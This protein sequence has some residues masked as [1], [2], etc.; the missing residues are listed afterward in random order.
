MMI[1]EDE[2]Y[3]PGDAEEDQAQDIGAPPL[4]PRLE[5]LA[6]LRRAAAAQPHS[7]LNVI[8]ERQ[9]RFLEAVWVD[10][11]LCSGR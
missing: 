4:A 11:G 7:V 8:D 1:E 2:G 10:R 3:Q 6:F 9:Q 5:H